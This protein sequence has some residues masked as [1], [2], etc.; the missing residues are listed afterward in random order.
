[1]I[2][3]NPTDVFLVR[4]AISVHGLNVELHLIEDGEQAIRFVAG[5]D[6]NPDARCPQLFLVDLNLPKLS[7][8]EVLAHIRR[9]NRCASSPVLI[10]TSSDA[11]NDRAQ[12]TALGAT[13]YFRKPSGYE[14][15]LRLGEV[16]Q[17]VLT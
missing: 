4:E 6:A 9:S 7:G 2:E 8:I 1:L 14:A 11:Q 13:A 12:S 5:I 15:Y 17:Q 3:D 10:I 16:I